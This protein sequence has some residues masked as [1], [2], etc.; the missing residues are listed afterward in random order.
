MDEVTLA[1]V[2]SILFTLIVLRA[3]VP[4]AVK[5]WKENKH[6]LDTEQELRK[7]RLKKLKEDRKHDKDTR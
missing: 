7:E 4:R 1:M 6:R 5:W 2:L 3:F